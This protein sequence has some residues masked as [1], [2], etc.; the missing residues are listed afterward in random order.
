MYYT[1]F[2]FR[3]V[4][5]TEVDAAA[6]FLSDRTNDLNFRRIKINAQVTAMTSFM[7]LFGMATFIIHIALTKGTTYTTEIHSMTIYLVILPYAFLMNTSHNKNRIIEYGWK[8]VLRNFIS[9][10]NT[11]IESIEN[12]PKDEHQNIEK[13]VRKIQTD[14]KTKIFVTPTPDT[15]TLENMLVLF[16]YGNIDIGF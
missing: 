16:L 10:S 11:S 7:E 1:S 14:K 2:Y 9:R 13:G 5:P 3:Q 12:F 6:N 4:R 8:N 15:G